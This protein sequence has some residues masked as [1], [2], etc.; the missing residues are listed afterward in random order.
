MSFVVFLK[1]EL[2]EIL[3]TYKAIVLPVIFL[4][5]GLLSP[6][7]AKF[8]PEL[9]KSM[10]KDIPI[11]IPDPV[12]T[13]AYMQLF[14]NLGQIGFIAMI[15]TFMGMVVEEKVKGSATLVL[16]KNLSRSQFILAKFTAAVLLYTVS[17]LLAVAACLY[18]TALLFPQMATDSLWLGLLLFWMYGVV[19]LAI[20]LLSSTVTPSHTMSAVA[21]FVGFALL[22]ASSSIPYVKKVSPGVLGTE[23]MN[24]L[25]GTTSFSDIL[26]PFVVGI[27]SI[28]ILVITSIFIFERQEI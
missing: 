16:T 6:L 1:K 5:F 14:K 17:Y 21:S 22:A 18:Y 12:F 11:P 23:N 7:A 9:I 24:I 20:T 27:A 15:L 3:K 10:V 25:L 19:L 13:D 8:T 28:I 4:F 26:I 2:R